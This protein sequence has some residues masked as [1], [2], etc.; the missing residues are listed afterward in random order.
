M[1]RTYRHFDLDE[2]RTL[3]RLVEA[4]RP[5]GEIATRLGRHPSTVYRELG[6]NRF[7]DGD[8]G[9][10][11]YFPV[12]AQDLAHRRRQRRRKLAA[13]DG[14]RAR[15][16]DR[17]KAGWSPQQIAG[18]L[19]REAPDR[20]S[21]CH[22][23]IYRH[24]HGPEGR[25]DDLY[26]HLPKARRRRGARYG[27][28]P[29]GTP[30][31]RERW[32]E[33]RPAEIADRQSF[34]HWEGDLL[35]FGKEAG[36][37][38]VTSLVERKSRFIFLLPNQDRRSSAVIAGIGEALR[39]LPEAARRTVTFDRGTE[40]A[41]Y[42]RLAGELA[43]ASYFC[44]PHSPWQKGGVE[45]A[46]GRARRFL[47]RHCE[48]D[49]L[50]RVRLRRLADRL[51]DTPRRCLGYRTPREVFEAHLAHPP[52]RPNL[53]PLTVAL[54]VE[55]AQG[56]RPVRVF[57]ADALTTPLTFASLDEARVYVAKRDKVMRVVLVTDE[58]DR[59]VVGPDEG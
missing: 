44:D 24:V 13:D 25:R 55:T 1:A 58:G 41:A 31:P 47:P 52:A 37:A 34:G 56:W 57:R 12:T 18:R 40:F 35:I 8:R 49:A 20:P 50:S 14:L 7:R 53:I 48:P 3:F 22:E 26:R 17:L 33:N 11:D 21:V 36:K 45:N 10:C 38:N 5:V 6:R 32:I 46:N 15:V 23:T 43:V 30:I 2:R 16:V 19:K 28:R 39:P 42:P 27:R 51:N 29:R 9:F 54:R 4:R 59:E